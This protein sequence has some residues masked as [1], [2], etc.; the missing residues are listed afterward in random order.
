MRFTVKERVE[1]VVQEISTLDDAE[2]DM[3]GEYFEDEKMRKDFMFRN[4]GK[5]NI[6]LILSH[7]DM[8]DSL[9]QKAIIHF[10]KYETY[11][12]V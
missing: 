6:E 1:I 4:D 5:P 12:R 2:L 10:A 3:I 7:F 8:L 9:K 11:K